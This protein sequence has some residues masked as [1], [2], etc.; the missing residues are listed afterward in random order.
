MLMRA[1]AGEETV[2]AGGGYRP[3]R[4]RGFALV[5][6][7]LVFCL[8]LVCIA[9][10]S[11]RTVTHEDRTAPQ[12][13]TFDVAEPVPPQD[14]PAPE[15]QEVA[16][17]RPPVPVPQAAALPPPLIVLPR[18]AVASA[19]ASAPPVKVVAADTTEL[20]PPPVAKKRSSGGGDGPDTW[21]AQVLARLNAVKTYPASARARRQQGTVLI[22]FTVNRQGQ[23]LKTTLAQSSGFGLLDRA[24][25]A[26]PKRTSP[27]PPPPE[28]VAGNE[29]ELTVPVEFYF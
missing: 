13:S 29:I 10:L 4:Q 14:A 27:L 25:L 6:T 22:R 9:L 12:V 19:P 5:L 23:V 26:L 28:D 18:S 24:G 8:P 2:I 3:A 21:H 7:L 20:P 1:K 16:E 11:W 15:E 17:P